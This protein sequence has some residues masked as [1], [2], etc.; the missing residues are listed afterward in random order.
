M[1]IKKKINKFPDLPGVYLMKDRTGAI[2][3]IG[4]AVSLKKRVKSYFQSVAKSPKTGLL[5]SK[6][7]DINF[8]KTPSEAEALLLEAALIKEHKPKYNI[9]LKDDK[10]YPMLRLSVNEKFATLTITR[11]RK[12]D[13]AKYFGPYTEAGLLK[14]SVGI[15]RKLF[16]LRTCKKLPNKVCL[17]HHLGYCSAPCIKNIQEDEYRESIRELELF[18]SGKK[19]DLIKELTKKM[20]GASLKKDYEAAAKLRDRIRALTS[21]KEQGG[22]SSYD[23]VENLK[24]ILGLKKPPQ[25][26]EAFDVSNIMGKFAVGSKVAFKNGFPYPDGYRRFKIKTFFGIDD[27]AMMRE[28]TRRHFENIKEENLNIPDLVVIDGGKGHL[29][30]A[31]EELDKL[32]FSGVPII[33][34]AKEFETIFFP[35]KTRGVVLRPGTPAL[36]LL[37]YIRDEAHRFAIGYHKILRNKSL[38]FSDLDNVE[39]VGTLRKRILLRHFG[40]IQKIKNATIAELKN[41]KGID[42]KTA[43]KIKEYFNKN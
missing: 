18:L 42:E 28:I 1:D 35:D 22:F 10:A 27:Y 33:G 2:I 9:E 6:I 25:Y 8:I 3:Y 19:D 32:G 23:Q 26:I 11:K 21:L 39:G 30:A 24:V 36:K 7:K 41:V 4:K 34:L 38:T 20:T 5:V 13:G 12:P 40:N 37:Q 16:R 29:T 15:L 14:E 43:E 31:K 17:N